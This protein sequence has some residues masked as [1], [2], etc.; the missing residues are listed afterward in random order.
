MILTV[1]DEALQNINRLLQARSACQ[2]ILREKYWS[3]VKGF[4]DE[5]LE[6]TR[7]TCK[8]PIEIAAERVQI[9]VDQML[10]L[11]TLA[12]C[13]EAIEEISNSVYRKAINQ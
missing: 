1:A 10:I 11:Y 2:S 5:I 4:K 12:G 8:S 7:K 3:I 13:I 9:M 6:L